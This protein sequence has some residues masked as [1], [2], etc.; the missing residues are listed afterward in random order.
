MVNGH[1]EIVDG[2]NYN[3]H[4][5]LK[6][7]LGFGFVLANADQVTTIK[8]GPASKFTV[9]GFREPLKDGEEK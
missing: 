4:N 1:T 5:S 3:T 7:G 2:L 8:I 9:R 6:V